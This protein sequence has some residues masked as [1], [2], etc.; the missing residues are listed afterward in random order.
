MLFL[1]LSFS[2]TKPTENILGHTGQGL[3]HLSVDLHPFLPS[4]SLSL[5]SSPHP[6]PRNVSRGSALCASV[7]F[8][9]DKASSKHPLCGLPGC[10]LLSCYSLE[11]CL[12]IFSSF[13][14]PLIPLPLLPLP[15][16]PYLPSLC[17]FC[18]SLPLYLSFSP[19][20]SHPSSPPSLS[21]PFS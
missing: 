17:S 19:L 3:H 4:S 7:P 15:L 8:S 18:A 13:P 10:F 16:F 5:S 21:S 9:E 1:L 6:A 12:T 2:E 14:A 20:S 11:I